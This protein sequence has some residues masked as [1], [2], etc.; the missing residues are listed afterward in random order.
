MIVRNP[1][2]SAAAVALLALV[3]AILCFSAQGVR[4]TPNPYCQTAPF[5]TFCKD[6]VPPAAPLPDN[7][8]VEIWWLVAPIWEFVLGPVMGELGLYH[9]AI[10]FRHVRT[11]RT[12]TIEF[13]SLFESPNATFPYVVQSDPKDPSSQKEIIWCNEGAICFMPF[14]NWTYYTNKSVVAM[15][16]G[17]V[18]NKFM[19]W[20][21]VENETYSLY[22]YTFS[23]YEQ[24]RQEPAYVDAYTCDDFAFRALGVL[25]W[26]GVDFHGITLERDFL[27][28]Y[29]SKPQLVDSS[30]P[31]NM[32]KITDFYGKYQLKGKSVIK[33]AQLLIEF[34]FA[35]KYILSF[36][37]Y[38]WL[39][40]HWPYFNWRWAHAPIVPIDPT[41]QMLEWERA[42]QQLNDVKRKPEQTTRI[43]IVKQD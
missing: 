2:L 29:S 1:G 22:Y 3:A 27:N 11:N 17:A 36:G 7:D 31:V 23:V 24:W 34:L 40:L 37:Q 4:P 35:D 39:Q 20:V 41:K 30:D 16:N 19:Q 15:T 12:W 5:W 8:A 43:D 14:I 25:A 32:K 6:G 33:A 42:Q 26:L 28:F 18:F 10:G 21:P 38:Y 9:S 13:E